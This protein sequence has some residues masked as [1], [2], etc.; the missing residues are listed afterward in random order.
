MTDFVIVAAAAAAL[1]APAPAPSAAPSAAVPAAVT[2]ASN[3]PTVGFR[4]YDTLA[5]CEQA[6]LALATPAGARLVCLP[7]EPLVGELASAY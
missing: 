3:A 1:L 7:V 5:A 6:T 4:T 2:V